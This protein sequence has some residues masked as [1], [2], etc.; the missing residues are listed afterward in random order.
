MQEKELFYER[1]P[2]PMWVF[3]LDTLYFLDV[4]LAAVAAYGYSRE[5]FLAMKAS[6]IRPP[7]DVPGFL[8]SIAGGGQAR[9]V[10]GTWRHI[11]KSGEIL[12]AQITA[13]TIAWNGRRAELVSVRDMTRNVLLQA[14]REALLV[15]EAGLRKVAE[16]AA[17]QFERL[18]SAVPGNVLVVEP[19]TWTVLAVSDAM[20]D[21]SGIPKSDFLGQSLFTALPGSG[22][23]PQAVSLLQMRASLEKVIETGAPDQPGI[24]YYP[25]TVSEA[26]PNDK[27]HRLWL[28]VNTPVKA[29]DGTI[30]YVMCTFEDVTAIVAGAAARGS[31]LDVIEQARAAFRGTGL[32]YLRSTLDLRAA[33]A[34]LAEQNS[35]LRTAQ[36]LLR[37]GLWKYEL[38]SGKLIWSPEV[39]EIYATSEAN[40]GG[41]FDAYTARVHPDDQQSMIDNYA[42][43][44]K[45]NQPFFEFSHRVLHP[46]GRVAHVR[47]VGEITETVDGRLLTGVVQDVTQQ[48]EQDNRLHLLD[49]SV[50]RLNDVVLIFEAA[51]GAESAQAPIVYVNPSF[52]RMT[53]LGLDEVLGQPVSKVMLETAPGVP[54]EVLTTAIADPV[55][56]RSDIRL[57]NR[58]GRVVPAEI[59]LVPVRGLSGALTHWVAV[60]RDMS[61][62]FAADERARTN[63]D[64]YRMLSRSTHDVVWDWDFTKD[65]ITWNENFRELSGNP[66]A[67]LVAATSSWKD[68]LHPDDRA[69]VLE[70]FF[71]AAAGDAETWSDEYRFVRDDGDVRFVF[72]RGFVAR[73]EAGRALRM[74]GSMVD[75]TAQKQAEA[76]LAQAEKLEALGQITGGVAHDFN[77]LLMIILGNAET[78]LDEVKGPRPRRQ[79]E[80]V[81]QAAERGR[82]LTSR[83]LTFA[84]RIPLKPVRLDL[85]EQVRR[86]AELLERTFRSNIR[87]ET[88]LRA[89]PAG[90]ECDPAQLEL[91]LLNLSVNARHAMPDGGVLKLA[92]ASR[93]EDGAAQVVLTISDTGEGMDTETLRRC[94]EPFFTTKPVGEGVGLGLSMGFGFMAQSGGKLLVES[95]RG[96]GTRVSLVFPQARPEQALAATA[97]T[98]TPIGGSEHILLVEDDSGVR[99]HVEGV[100]LDLGYRVTACQN[101]DAAIDYLNAGGGADLILSDLVMPGKADVRHLVQLA[102]S[103]FPDIEVL[104]SSGYP[105]AAIEKDGR[106]AADIDLLPKP[107]RRAELAGRLRQLLDRRAASR[108][109]AVQES[110]V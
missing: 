30:S 103:Y 25:V 106:L 40:F 37:I 91:V 98:V 19:E 59:D 100:L 49:Q 64:R 42:V 44:A 27:G 11:K 32:P 47:G 108:N 87:I 65:Q 14:E 72:D 62:K 78:L 83:L 1:H 77:N 97:P 99:Q 71:G 38:W 105:K 94:L 9:C 69:R 43:F 85:N 48:I 90:I 4:N 56:L 68:R 12:H 92:T 55:S 33:I 80:L 63:E 93:E 96:K 67:P 10:P 34:Q 82:D 3:D 101:A 84:R 18:F 86:S 39:H 22:E 104:Y 51:A 46:D 28:V 53:G 8:E 60:I 76:R 95:A 52:L 24:L 110:E 73:D 45:S 79:L 31:S 75:I 20:L 13:H 50:S 36:R 70:G 61:E 15:Q 74:V 54:L 17:A 89:A 41:T 57:V 7:E 109:A 35:N 6:D 29:A 26:D 107:Y 2:D 21:V 102:R 81:L 16:A 23:T 5:E 58:E 88:E 66:D